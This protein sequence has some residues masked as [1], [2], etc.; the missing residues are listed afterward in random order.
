LRVGQG[1][2]LV[3]DPGP[4]EELISPEGIVIPADKT[5]ELLRLGL[6]PGAKAAIGM[7]LTAGGGSGG[8]TTLSD[9]YGTSKTWLTNKTK[10]PTKGGVT[11]SGGILSDYYGVTSSATEVAAAAAAT[12]AARAASEAAA[13]VAQETSTAVA[14]AIGGL[15]SQMFTQQQ[16][17]QNNIQSLM[18]QQGSLNSEMLRT[19][20]EIREVLLRQGTAA[21]IRDSVVEGSQ[22]L[23][24]G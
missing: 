18:R 16:S 10:K 19:L 21:D 3:G 4:N 23:V 14:S 8:G 12:Q 11:V 7:D 1:W 6:V 5:R 15:G 17:N 2:V 20:E 22:F 13:A 9:I 24:G